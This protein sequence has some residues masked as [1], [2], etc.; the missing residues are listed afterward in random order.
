M[1]VK[2]FQ[3]Q[4]YRHQYQ[5]QPFRRGQVPV[6]PDKE[7]GLR[8]RHNKGGSVT[9]SQGRYGIFNPDFREMPTFSK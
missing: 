9:I 3:D 1:D 4:R 7:I 6:D 2:H 5:A 8:R